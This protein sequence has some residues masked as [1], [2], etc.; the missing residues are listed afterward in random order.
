MHPLNFLPELNASLNVA[1]ALFLIA[2]RF[3]IRGEN[4]SPRG[5]N[6]GSENGRSKNRRAHAACMI[7]AF[8][9]SMAFLVS[10]LV[11]H[12]IAGTV[13]FTGEGWIRPVYFVILTT[14]TILAAAVPVLAIITLSRALRARF[15]AH[16]RIA[17]ITFPIWLYVSVTGVVIY[18]L[19]FGAY[20]RV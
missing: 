6:G 15:D 4:G 7:S 8:T 16:R 1:S 14:H 10:Y 5:E 18:A 20:P 3:F 13:R 17:R 2:G 9:L 11:Y 12:S 19:L